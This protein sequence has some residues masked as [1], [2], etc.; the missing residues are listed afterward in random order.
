MKERK[1]HEFPI[2][3]GERERGQ[4]TEVD[5][6][7]NHARGV[8]A[9][10]SSVLEYVEEARVVLQICC[11]LTRDARVRRR[12]RSIRM[13]GVSTKGKQRRSCRTL[14]AAELLY[15]VVLVCVSPA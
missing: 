9:S 15:F 10:L 13:A 5:F 7:T 4:F 2:K 6:V 14:D 1:K 12:R 3:L 11:T 8:L